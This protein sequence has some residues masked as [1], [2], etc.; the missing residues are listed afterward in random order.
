MKDHST[1]NCPTAKTAALLSDVWTM[2]IVRDLM[3]HSMRF[4]DLHESLVG[5]STRTLTLKLHK[6]ES[7]GILTKKDTQYMITKKGQSL[8][9]IF[10]EMTKYGKKYLSV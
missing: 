2:L 7:D 6:L 1:A 5:I 10:A 9:S 8:A 3:K 4:C